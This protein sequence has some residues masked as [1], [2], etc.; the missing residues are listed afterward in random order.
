ML[1]AVLAVLVVT[2]CLYLTRNRGII[3]KMGIPIDPPYL[4]FGSEP[5]ALHKV[6][7]INY[8]YS[9]MFRDRNIY[10]QGGSNLLQ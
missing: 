9:Q 10:F 1:V 6:S 8:L 2:L 4:V 7:D 5:R 3:E